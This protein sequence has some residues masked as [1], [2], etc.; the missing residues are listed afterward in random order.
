M[1]RKWKVAS[2]VVCWALLS[3]AV[4]L[5]AQDASTV[6]RPT[7]LWVDER[8]GQL[9]IRPG[10]GRVPMNFGSTVDAAKIEQQVE[11]RTNAKVQ[12]AVAQAQQEQQLKD[13][14]LAKK[15][16][17]MEPAWHNYIANWQDKF[18]VGTL[19][20]GDYRFYSLTGFQPQELTQINNP[21]PGNNNYNSFDIT[22]TYLNFYFFPT[23]DWTLRLT[24][25][26]YRTIGCQTSGAPCS[27]N[28]GNATSGS[29]SFGSN[30]DGNLGVR[31]KYAYLQY[32]NLWKDMPIL[33]GGTVTLGEIPNPLVAWEEDLYGY[34]FVNLTPWNYYGL[35][36][37][38]L[39]VSL[40]GPV[41]LFGGEKTYLDYGIGVYNNASFH[42]FEQSENK[43]LMG[44]LTAYPFGAD[45]RFQGLG[46]TGFY[47]YGYGNTT[48]DNMDIPTAL[49]ATNAH[50]ERIAALLHYAQPMWNLVGEF[51]YGQNAFNLAN[52]FSGG[53]P[54]DAFGIA[55]GTGISNNNPGTQVLTGAPLTGKLACSTTSPCYNA[56]GSYGA[57]TAVWRAILQNGRE[58]NIGVDF[59]GHFNI[60]NTKL[61][62]FGMFQWFMPNDN[63]HK[64]PLDFQRWVV[65]IAYQYNEY[66]RFAIDS[67]NLSYYHDQFGMPVGVA[68]GF[69]YTPGVF[70]G[71]QLPSLKGFTIPNLVPRDTHS[72]FANVEFAY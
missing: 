18:R 31:M 8:T 19:F 1:K 17:A 50:F 54:S 3:T 55:S 42:A 32:A 72:I 59:F 33:K 52:L 2:M 67:Q 7:T 12:A 29:N 27:D 57:Q 35:S 61:S 48:P 5:K 26:I 6:S 24:P 20:Y 13:A 49:K 38:Q 66:L 47:N 10:R 70:N 11:D 46:L 25:N 71:R 63:I 14:Q 45:W 21:G 22:R 60:P 53:G 39:G 30:L 36:S 44:R 56:F 34:R 40:E 41:K 62:L 28:V 65:G 4:Q 58:R 51:D 64:D 68:E 69:N 16:D 43:Q 37:T 23:K 15:V 9:F